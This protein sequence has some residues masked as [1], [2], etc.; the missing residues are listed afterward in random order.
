MLSQGEGSIELDIFGSVPSDM[1]Y[2][3]RVRFTS[4]PR[5]PEPVKVP[6]MSSPFTSPE[7]AMS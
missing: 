6:A 3:W 1:P 2:Y 4:S 5:N 7:N